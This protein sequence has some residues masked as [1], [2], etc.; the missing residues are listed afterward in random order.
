MPRK[1]KF[2][3]AGKEWIGFLCANPT[4]GL[5]ILIGEVLP[6]MLDKQGTLTIR[7][8]DQRLT[9]PTCG[10]ESVYPTGQARR[11]RTVDKAELS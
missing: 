3:P 10:H 2:A 11:F 6:R 9:C 7:G 4:C 1:G 5:P 8:E